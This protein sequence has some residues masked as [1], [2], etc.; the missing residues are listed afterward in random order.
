MRQSVIIQ[1]LCQSEATNHP[2]KKGE[3]EER[4]FRLSLCDKWTPQCSPGNV[5]VD[6]FRHVFCDFLIYSIQ[7]KL[8]FQ[9]LFQL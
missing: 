8:L 4:T 2:H 7:M 5:F 6:V 3:T 1:M 9:P